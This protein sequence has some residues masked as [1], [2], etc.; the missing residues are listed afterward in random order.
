[1]L[2]IVS[3]NARAWGAIQRRA[4]RHDIL[5]VHARV[6]ATGAA[7]GPRKV[8]IPPNMKRALVAANSHHN[9]ATHL[10]QFA[11]KA[12]DQLGPSI[13]TLRGLNETVQS[14]VTAIR[15]VFNGRAC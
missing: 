1:M 8:L 6:L 7:T 9:A 10:A 2:Q 13:D 12:R 11:G 4:I 5:H 14:R 15:N 3:L